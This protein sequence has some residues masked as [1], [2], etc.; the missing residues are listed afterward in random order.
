MPGGPTFFE[1]EKEV[2]MYSKEDRE[3]ILADWRESGMPA[4]TFC[5]QPGKPSR[6]SLANWLRQAEAGMLD[7]PVRAVRGRADRPKHARYPEATKREALS[8]LAKGMRPCDVARRLNVSGS[9]TLIRWRDEAERAKMAPEVIAVE[10]GARRAPGRAVGGVAELEARIAELELECAV[11]KELVR[12]PK[13]EGPARLS[14]RLK[15]ELGERLRRETGCSLREACRALRISKSTY[16]YQLRAMG[17]GDPDGEARRAAVAER[18]RAEF[19]ASGG[20]YGYRR[21]VAAAAAGVGGREPM[22][23]SEREARDAMRA[24]GMVARRTR[25]RPWSSY[26][27]E[28]DDRPANAPLRDGGG[29]DFSASAP[30]ELLVTDV[31]EF[32][33]GG[34]SKVYLSPVIDCFDGMPAAWSLSTHPDSAL[35]DSS[36]RAALDSLPAGCS[37]TVHTDGGAT[38]RSR[39]WKALCAERGVTRSMSRKGC[40]PDNARAEGFFGV[41]KEELYNGRDWSSYT[42]ERFI[43][44]VDDYMRWYRDGRLKRFVDDGGRVVYDTIAGRRRRLGVTA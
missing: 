18:V 6:T 23:I 26:G 36:L 10:D 33:V 37:P 20:T 34:R 14:S 13:S 3:R 27:G 17:A 1:S 30:G 22:R 44:V 39:S 31:T 24:G 2:C 29:H 35:C 19:A 16:C 7:V 40:C 43:G 38:Y 5:A 28:V 42:P 11:L 9:S 4:A 21:V 41:L 25:R 12:D 15:T 32:K 8:L